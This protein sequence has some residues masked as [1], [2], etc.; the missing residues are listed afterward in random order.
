MNQFLPQKHEKPA[1][2]SRKTYQSIL[3]FTT[4]HHSTYNIFATL[5]RWQD[6]L[7]LLFFL[8]L[9]LGAEVGAVN[10]MGYDDWAILRHFQILLSI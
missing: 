4:S 9:N 1:Q 7:F 5:R 10:K 8:P 6:Y 3:L 2:I